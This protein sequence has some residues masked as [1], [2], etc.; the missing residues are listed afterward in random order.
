MEPRISD[1]I[2]RYSLLCSLVASHMHETDSNVSSVPL[3]KPVSLT[4]LQIR[5]L[6]N[7]QF[8]SHSAGWFMQCW[9]QL[10]TLLTILAL[11]WNSMQHT[12]RKYIA[13]HLCFLTQFNF[14]FPWDAASMSQDGLGPW[15]THM[16]TNRSDFLLIWIVL[17]SCILYRLTV[18][19][20]LSRLKSVYRSRS[21]AR[22]NCRVYC[23]Y[24]ADTLPT[25][26]PA[27]ASWNMVF[28]CTNYHILITNFILPSPVTYPLLITRLAYSFTR[29]RF[30]YSY[31]DGVIAVSLHRRI[32]YPALLY[33]ASSCWQRF[34]KMALICI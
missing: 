15:Y 7:Y 24:A 26:M 22:H 29:N 12:Y 32:C 3:R 23:G 27:R 19:L 25:Y 14:S 8:K 17:R 9:T 16:K 21:T 30:G 28:N 11:A 20:S 33:R 10:R 13:N 6:D 4:P 18:S 1:P 34:S 31:R 5:G 2:L